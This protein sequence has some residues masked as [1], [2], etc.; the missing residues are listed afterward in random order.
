ML[1]LIKTSVS[2]NSQLILLRWS[3]W[4]IPAELKTLSDETDVAVIAYKIRASFE[5]NGF[6]EIY[7]KSFIEN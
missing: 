2:S 3:T 7:R 6:I 1:C 5:S 4:I